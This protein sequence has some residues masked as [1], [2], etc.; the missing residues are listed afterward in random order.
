MF[1]AYS[2]AGGHGTYRLLPAFGSDG[3]ALVISADGV[4]AWSHLVS[5]F[6]ASLQ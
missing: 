6:L 5:E 1:D 3:H 4:A 2:A